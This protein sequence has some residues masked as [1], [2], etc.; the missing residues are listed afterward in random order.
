MDKNTKAAIRK[1]TKSFMDASEKLKQAEQI[2]NLA[3]MEVISQNPSTTELYDLTA[4]LPN[5]YKGTRR[6]FEKIYRMENITP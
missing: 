2:L 4:V 6:I 5:T 3:V 1:A